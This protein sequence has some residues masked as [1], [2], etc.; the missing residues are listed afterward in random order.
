MSRT[1]SRQAALSIRPRATGFTLL[2]ILVAASLALLMLGLGMMLFSSLLNISDEATAT[3]EM[4]Q[5]LRAAANLI[6]QDLMMAA[7]GIPIGGL[8]LPSGAN[9]Q[10][11]NRP[12][13][14]CN[15]FP[16][17][18]GVIPAISPG[19]GLGPSQASANVD[20]SYLAGAITNSDEITILEVD[21][22]SQINQY[23]LAAESPTSITFNAGT[24][25]GSG[26]SQLRT[27]DL[28]MLQNANGSAL[29]MVTNINGDVVS[30]NAGDPLQINQPNAAAGNFAAILSGSPPTTA[31]RL[32]MISYY[33][34]FSNPN[35]PV[36][37]RQQDDQA[38]MKVAANITGLQFTY[39]L[40]D[41]KTIDQ[42][43][44]VQPNQIRKVNFVISARSTH[45]SLKTGHYYTNSIAT[46]VMIRNLEYRNRY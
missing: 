30:L 14:C 11:V 17:A 28:L 23:P 5:N 27:G 21:P 19:Y 44:V 46:A 25:L 13:P 34:D 8:P 12:G 35:E 32:L 41:G 43:T 38:A 15:T 10:P 31:Y 9:A 24:N 18:L 7:A 33:L 40:S 6:S 22:L 36:L 29:A 2:E 37:M 20:T 45:R 16:A 26:V 1:I 39:D 42:R 3:A 4:N